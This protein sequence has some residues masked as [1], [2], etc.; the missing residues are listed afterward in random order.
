MRIAFLVH[1]FPL[2]SETFI[3]NQAT[4]LIERGHEVDVYTNR[5]HDTSKVH[6]DVKK[7]RLLERT[8]RLPD[9]PE[10]AIPRILGGM[11]LLIKHF[12]RNPVLFLRSLNPLRYG[13][14]VLNFRLVYPAIALLDNPVYDVV[15]CQFGTQGFCGIAFSKL[16]HPRPKLVTT[17]RGYDISTYVRE[18]GDRVYQQLFQEG[19]FFLANCEFFRQRAI[20]LGCSPD[21]IIVHRSGLDASKF[22][23][24]ARHVDLNR[25][26]RIATTGRLVEK[27]GIEYVIQAVAKL[28]EAYPTLQYNI[29]GD[30]VLKPSLQALID[31]LGVNQSVHLLGWKNEQEM[32]EI[33]RETDLFVAPS[34]TAQDGNQDAPVN[35]LKEA[36]AMGLPTISTQHGGIPELIEDGVNGFLVP[37]RDVDALV[38][39]LDYLI[40]HPQ[41]WQEMGRAGRAT[42]ENQYNL[43]TLNDRL[44]EVYQGLHHAKRPSSPSPT[45]INQQPVIG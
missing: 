2:L 44:V 12:H 11:G 43:H 31:Q 40:Q 3:L 25:G 22:P 38:D 30:G 23:F 16:I 4:G 32:A 35:V 33:L 37:E 5:I 42:V 10:A 7:Y 18:K 15:H 26:V 6:P 8:Y 20:Q 27:K 17:F 45:A 41:R 29:I 36:M 1:D 21:S 28:L 9:I 14:R 13:W 34:I 19:D 39:R 24:T